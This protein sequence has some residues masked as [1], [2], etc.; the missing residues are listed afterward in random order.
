MTNSK[1]HF[2]TPALEPT[3]VQRAQWAKK[4]LAVFTA[5]TY[6]GDMPDTMHPED[7]ET[8][9]GDLIC[10]LLHF[11]HYHPRMDPAVIHSHALYIF[12]QELA[13]ESALEPE[14]L[15]REE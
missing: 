13:E 8:A 12:E 11:A 5:E 6:G 7:L 3:N 2:K 4:A 10:D 1:K 15:V 9:V 14:T